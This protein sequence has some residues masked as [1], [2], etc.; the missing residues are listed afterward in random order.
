MTAMLERLGLD[1]AIAAKADRKELWDSVASLSIDDARYRCLACKTVH[2]C[3]AWLS[4]DATDGN[5]FCPNAE[6]FKALKVIM[7]GQTDQRA[8]DSN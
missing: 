7:D 1:P 8:T 6:L 3:E 5:D 4:T 2:E